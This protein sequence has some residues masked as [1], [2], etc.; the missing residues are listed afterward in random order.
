[1]LISRIIL[2][3]WRNF[4][5]VN[6]PLR[7]RMFLVGANASGKSN[8][9]DVFRFLRELSTTQGGGLQKA[10]ADRGGLTKL[11][12]LAARKEPDIEIEVHLSNNPGDE[13]PSWRYQLSFYQETRGK[14]Q[15][16]LR[17]EQ[18][19]KGQEQI[20]LRPDAD[21]K[22]DE[23]RLSQTHLEQINT[24]KEFRE[25]AEFF[26]KTTYLHL[27]PQLLRYS[28]MF[29]ASPLEND[30]FGQEFLKRIANTPEKTRN[31]RL[32]KIE[33]ALQVAVPKLKE[34]KFLRD[35]TDSKPHL[36]A[37]YEHWRPNAGWQQED[38]FSDGTLRLLGLFWSLLENDS[39]LLLE[40][41]ELSLNGAIVR[42]LPALIF[43]IQRQR[44][45][46][47]LLSTHSA[48]L[49]QDEGIDGR[50]VLLLQVDKEGTRI[51]IPAELTEVRALLDAGLS[52][53]DAVLPR[54]KPEQVNQLSTFE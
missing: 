20:L 3:N 1:M 5:K 27:V 25:V 11:R 47:L 34:L 19:W 10:V 44:K 40:E 26:D 14:R 53:A 16:L 39:L 52:I 13:Y 48:D 51:S 37:L 42:Q 31:S 35:K 2:K 33:K 29:P 46:Q 43:R 41:P 22:Q 12:C 23:A 8:F 45:R 4:R 30:P 21:D 7:D 50:E 36:A 32:E 17:S 28:S 6:V 49:L 9:L 54:T 18:V 15:T 38:Q 24:N